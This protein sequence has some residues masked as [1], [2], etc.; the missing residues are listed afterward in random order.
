MSVYFATISHP[1]G[2]LSAAALTLFATGFCA[3]RVNVFMNDKMAKAA[4]F[5]YMFI[6]VYMKVVI[7]PCK[8]VSFYITTGSRRQ[9]PNKVP[10]W[11]TAAEVI[12]ASAVVYAMA[13]SVHFHDP[14]SPFM[15]AIVAIH[16]K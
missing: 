13:N 12:H 7:T 9:A 11:N 2:R 10:I 14:V 4:V 8:S 1:S 15:A 16:G 6:S 3:D 5:I